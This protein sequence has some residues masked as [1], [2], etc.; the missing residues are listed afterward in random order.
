MNKDIGAAVVGPGA[1]D[2]K[3]HT[4]YSKVVP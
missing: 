3:Y 1:E 2:S 4:N